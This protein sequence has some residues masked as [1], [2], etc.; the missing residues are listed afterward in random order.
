MNKEFLHMQKLAGIITESEYKEKI[1]MSEGPEQ[2][3]VNSISE[4]LKSKGFEIVTGKRI[5]DAEDEIVGGGDGF[6]KAFV[7]IT[8][9][10]GKKSLYIAV[11]NEKE[12]RPIMEELYKTYKDEGARWMQTRGGGKV[13]SIENINIP[14]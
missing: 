8:E 3:Y 13:L 4:K 14:E 5:G 7:G 9:G 6:K 11:S 1:R 12:N 2:G 10:G